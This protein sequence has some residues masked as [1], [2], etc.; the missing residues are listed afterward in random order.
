MELDERS[1]DAALMRP[2]GNHRK[3]SYSKHEDLQSNYSM[4][5]RTQTR[6]KSW[7]ICASLSPVLDQT[8]T[9]APRSMPMEW[10]QEIR[11]AGTGA[12]CQVAR[13]N[14]ATQLRQ[15]FSVRYECGRLTPCRG[16]SRA[17]PGYALFGGLTV[18]RAHASSG[19]CPLRFGESAFNLGREC[20]AW[21]VCWLSNREFPACRASFPFEI[22][23][24][25]CP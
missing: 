11:C 23:D 6:G 24:W 16:S 17:V 10:W 22:R 9:Q 5:R 21:H 8:R 20:S 15:D 18:K 25:R 4:R 19:T 13:G 1:R 2:K 12:T 7:S 14:A 3:R